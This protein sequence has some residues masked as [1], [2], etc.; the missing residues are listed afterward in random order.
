MGQR[1]HPDSAEFS[2]PTEQPSLLRCCLAEGMETPEGV[3]RVLLVM[4]EAHDFLREQHGYF[5]AEVDVRLVSLRLHHG[6]P[7][8][9]KRRRRIALCRQ[10]GHVAA[11][12]L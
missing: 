10:V 4:L 3:A 12:A 9:G 8:R 7:D 11:F 1:Y 5:E 2:Q 6:V